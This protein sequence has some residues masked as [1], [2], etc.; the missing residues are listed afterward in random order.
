MIADRKNGPALPGC[1]GAQ[2]QALGTRRGD[3]FFPSFSQIAAPHI[4][5]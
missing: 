3:L 2:H 4:F 1:N 5:T